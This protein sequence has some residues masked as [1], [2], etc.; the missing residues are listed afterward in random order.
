[1]GLV[2]RK[3]P[4]ADWT[5]QRLENFLSASAFSDSHAYL[6]YRR[7]GAAGFFFDPL[8]FK[9]YQPHFATWDESGTAPACLSEELAQGRMRF[10]EDQ[11]AETGFPPDWHANPFTGERVSAG[12]HWSQIDDFDHTDIRIIWEPSRFGFAYPLVR[13]YW[14]TGDDRY[15]EIFWQMVEDWRAHNPPQ[16]G[17]N[18]KCGQEIS[19][20]VMAWCFGLYGFLFARAT[21]PQR[22]ASLAEMIAVSGQRV[23][24]NLD[25][26]LSQQNNHGISEGVG[27]WTIG[28]LFPEFKSAERWKVAGRSVLESHGRELIYDD[29]SFSQHSV[30]YHR[31]MLHDYLWALRLGD[32]SGEP[33]SGEL[34][35]RVS[36]S[37]RFLY[38]IQDESSGRV[39]GYGQNDGALIL[40]L[41]N[42]DRQDFRPVIQAAEYLSKATR[43]YAQGAWDEDLLWLF[44]PEALAAPVAAPVREDLIAESGGYYTLRSETGFV[45]IRC[46]SFRHRPGQAD[47]LH[48]DVWWRGQNMALDA[49]TYSYN[50][51]APWNNALAHTAYHNTVVVDG[52]DQMNRAG[53]FLWLPWAEGRVRCL[54]KSAAGRLSYWEGEH[55]GYERLK[56][57]VTHRRAILRLGGECWLILDCLNSREE[58]LYRLHWLL[59]D[60][61]YEWSERDGP[62]TLDTPAGAYYVRIGSSSSDTTFS[63]A[64]ADEKSPRGWRAACYN[65]REP[66]LSMDAT[67][68]AKR[69]MF[70]TLFAPEACR[71]TADS[72]SLEIYAGDWHASIDLGGGEKS[73]IAAARSTGVI[74][75]SLEML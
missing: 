73:L 64:R 6:D 4:V 37:G 5:A 30:N 22:V 50:A 63:L 69:Q 16:Q 31:L 45:F 59:P 11:S 57:A 21:S 15:A 38:Q 68:R 36:L 58:H 34:K 40:P 17:A 3:T 47:M 46:A 7:N 52:L 62:L 1:M 18:W 55:N 28:T 61:P 60:L 67:T 2:R 10:F 35:E 8:R 44:G 19:F 32:I 72:R 51:P 66:A 53:K 74:E 41:S 29:G 23:E 48:A 27:L 9:D 43:C 75:D 39:P 54:R 14:R 71:V 20:R 26:A 24:A 13:A 25:Y 56:S 42:C 70:W 65:R 33:L 49:G 12:L